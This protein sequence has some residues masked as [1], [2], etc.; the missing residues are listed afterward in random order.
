MAL[1]LET[2]LD[3]GVVGDYWRIARVNVECYVP[4]PYVDIVL[5]LWITRQHCLDGKNFV[6]NVIERMNLTD[7]DSTYSYDFR[8]CIYNSLKTLPQWANAIDIVEPDGS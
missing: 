6:Y 5:C 2:E 4:T 8:A 3:S 1:Q 7:I